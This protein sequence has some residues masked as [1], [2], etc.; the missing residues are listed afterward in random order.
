MNGFPSAA[1]SVK[2]DDEIKIEA[3]L[4][5]GT[6]DAVFKTI[7]RISS[8]EGYLADYQVNSVTKGKDALA[9]VTVKVVFE[10]SKP[11]VIGHGVSIDTM[12]ASA[13]AYIGA[14]N[15]YIYMKDTLTNKNK[16]M[17]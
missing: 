14:L 3:G 10:D 16:G 5:K 15:S 9:K 12:V 13:K 11:A 17:I 8:I 2:V 7:D 1:V 4:G 6:I